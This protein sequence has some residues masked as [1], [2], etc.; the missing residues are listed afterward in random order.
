M[1]RVK[2]KYTGVYERKSEVRSH[3]GKTDACFDIAY[4]HDGKLIWEKAGWTSEGYTA[5]LASQIRA[6]RLRTIHHR[7]ELP[8]QRKKAPYFRDV[9]TEYLTW[10][11][12]NKTR[13]GRDEASRY[14]NY[15]APYFG[16][17]R[18]TEISSF[19]LERLKT[20]LSKNG[21]AP[22]T[23]KHILVIFR[24]MFNK[25]FLWGMYKGENPI[26][27]VK[28]PTVQNQRQRFLSHEEAD[29]LL[30][31]LAGTSKQLH[32]MTLLSLHC[33]LRAGEI[34]NIKGQDLDFENKLINIADPKNKEAR[35]AYMTKAIKEMFLEHMPVSPDEHIF[36][37]RNGNKVVAI[38]QSF[39]KVIQELGFNEDITDRRQKIT[40][41]SLRHTFASWLALQ[42]EPILTIK[43]L[44]G[45]KSL[46][47][48]TK[49]SHLMPDQKRRATL[50]LEKAFKRNG[51][52]MAMQ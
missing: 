33:G 4:K 10:A 20:D 2:T 25:A 12:Q 37:D 43:E 7:D 32:D 26:K 45:H 1:K 39:R 6:D 41:H 29:L 46:A 36:K 18:L 3:N 17:K 22:A 48:T 40:F 42:G 31:E 14:K 24:E 38:S 52:V 13:G 47:M 19:D 23:I 34:F 8:K 27:G 11:K 51:A 5:K 16:D 35:K 28:M 15:L 30:T 44:L 49:Y 9:A 50:N 21:L